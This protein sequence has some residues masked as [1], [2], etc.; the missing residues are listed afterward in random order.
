MRHQVARWLAALTCLAFLLTG[1]VPA[2]A[3]K[4]KKSWPSKKSG[5]SRHKKSPSAPK[6]GAKAAPAEED[7]DEGE[8]ETAQGGDSGGGDDEKADPPFKP[9]KVAKSSDEDEDEDGEKSSS[10]SDD[11]DGG[12]TVVRRKQRKV[13]MESD[14]TAPIALEI[15]AGP[16]IVNRSFRFNE[17]LS[18][19]AEYKLPRG[20]APFIDAAIYPLAFAGRGVMA[21]IGIVG[22]Y[23]RLVGTSTVTK[24]PSGATA[25]TTTTTAQQYEVGLRGRIPLD[26]HEV[27][28]TGTYGQQSFMP[29]TKSPPPSTMAIPNV[30]YSFVGLG[31]DA[32]LRFGGIV[33]LGAHLGTRLV[34]DTG[35]LGKTWFKKTTTTAVDAGL[36]LAVRVAPMF[37]VVAG[38]DFV[39]YGFAFNPKPSDNLAFVAGGA[40][41]QY[42]S[43]Y[44]ALRVSLNGG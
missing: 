36:S 10:D 2:E 21:N 23:E 24:D 13:A 19:A 38:G 26:V 3:A 44:L 33:T 27:G 42:I 22:R 28:L 41:D 35:S 6:A 14:G 25:S 30:V 43:G 15:M 29:A 11:D 1:A 31:A 12:S 39:R 37:E 20:A 34:T 40:V 9:K 7:D 8:E 5:K 32:R 16:R 4:H 18:D 17:P